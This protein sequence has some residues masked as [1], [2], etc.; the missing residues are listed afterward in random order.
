MRGGM[1]DGIA[2]IVGLVLGVAMLILIYYGTRTMLNIARET[3]QD[4]PAQYGELPA[5]GEISCAVLHNSK[6]IQFWALRQDGTCRMED[7][8]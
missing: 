4:A 8:K 3:R 6:T 7:R 2:A 1:G 5:V